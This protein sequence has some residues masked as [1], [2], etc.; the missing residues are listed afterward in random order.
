MEVPVAFEADA[1]RYE[2]AKV[3]RSVSPIH[4]E[5]VVVGQYTRSVPGGAAIEGRGAPADR[6]EL[7]GYK[8]HRGVP[9]DSTTET[10]VA[11]RLEIANWR[12]QGVPF[13]LRTGRRLPKRSTQIVIHFRYPPVSLFHPIRSCPIRSNVLVITLQPD[14]G[15]DL[16]FEVKTPGEPISMATQHLDFRYSEAFAAVPEAY[17]TLLLDVMTGDPTLFVRSDE[18]E[19]S[20]R[21]FSPLART[22]L[23]LF[24]Y[25]TGSWGPPEADALLARDQRKW[26]NP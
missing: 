24:D 10:F 6:S 16:S 19:E 13:Y 9:A 26:R 14:E 25:P 17:E 15:F 5:D 1:I 7:E 12:W 20:W 3:L 4:P 8:E 21:L 11:M 22:P 2:K 18:V 23:P